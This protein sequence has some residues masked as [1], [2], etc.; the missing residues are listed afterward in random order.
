MAA[1]E[2][3]AAGVPLLSSQTGVIERVQTRPEMLFPSG[4]AAALA[5][6][7]NLLLSRWG[8]LDFDI[9]AIQTKIREQFHIERAAAQFDGVYRD[10]LLPMQRQ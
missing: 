5:E 10:L 2:T 3:L 4:N 8:S 1:I 6:R 7:L 9:S